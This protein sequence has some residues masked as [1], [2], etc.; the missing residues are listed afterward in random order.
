MAQ[1][2]GI[3]SSRALRWEC[4]GG[5]G[6]LRNSKRSLCSE[7][8]ED[9]VWRGSRCQTRYAL[10]VHFKDFGFILGKTGAHRRVLS[11]RVP[12]LNLHANRISLA[13]A[14]FRLCGA[15]FI[16]YVNIGSLPTPQPQARSD[17]TGLSTPDGHKPGMQSSLGI[18]HFRNWAIPHTSRRGTFL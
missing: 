16:A 10:K 7:Q 13:G 12:T 17:D 14:H 8:C 9:R 11:K 6:S 2:Q 5:A 3:T 18:K 4:A 1:A 15:F